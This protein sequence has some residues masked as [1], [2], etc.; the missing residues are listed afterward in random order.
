MRERAHRPR[1][2]QLELVERPGRLL[3]VCRFESDVS[4]L[5]FRTVGVN[6]KIR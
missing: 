5:V 6:L 3:R 2:G 4:K 1:V